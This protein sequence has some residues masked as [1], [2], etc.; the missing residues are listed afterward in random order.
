[1]PFATFVSSALVCTSCTLGVHENA[2]ICLVVLQSAEILGLIICFAIHSY[3]RQLNTTPKP[4]RPGVC[5]MTSALEPEIEQQRQ[6]LVSSTTASLLL[7]RRT[8]WLSMFTSVKSLT[9]AAIFKLCLLLRMC[10]RRVVFPD[11]RAPVTRVTGS[12]RFFGAQASRSRCVY[13]L[14]K[15]SILK[16]LDRSINYYCCKP[17]PFLHTS[18]NWKIPGRRSKEKKSMN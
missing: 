3:A 1:M 12:F 11:P 6:P 8:V 13:K 2:V 9:A 15:L 17:H 14:H 16:I 7:F 18:W 4:R 5:C 10:P